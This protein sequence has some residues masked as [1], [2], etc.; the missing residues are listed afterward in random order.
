MAAWEMP[1]LDC[2]PIIAELKEYNACSS[3]PGMTWADNNWHHPEVVEERITTLAKEK[4]LQRRKGKATVCTVLGVTVV[5]AQR[6]RHLDKQAKQEM[7][8]SLQD[9]VKV[10]Q[11]QL[12]VECNTTQ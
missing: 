9:L 11:G 4:K 12:T 1:V 5:T 3:P 8:K 10:L 6:N 2:F 7:V